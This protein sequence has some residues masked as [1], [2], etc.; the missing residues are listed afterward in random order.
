[1]IVGGLI[2]GAC[3]GGAW[4][5]NLSIFKTRLPP[6]AKYLITLG[7]TVATVVGYVIVAGVLYA[8]FQS[9]DAAR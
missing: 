6:V 8:I 4:F 5:A 7:V 9:N 2:G 1:M 3:G